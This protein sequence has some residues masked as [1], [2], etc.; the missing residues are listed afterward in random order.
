[1][2]DLPRDLYPP[3]PTEA[4]LPE[5]DGKPVDN[6]L[7]LLAAFILRSIL[8]QIW[9][10][11]MDWFMGVNLGLYDQPGAPAIGPDAFLAI[12]A[13]R[14]R[15]NQKLRLSYVVWE[16]KIMPQ[17]VLEIVSQTPGQEYGDKM[18]KYAAMGI[19]YYTIYN[20]SHYRR[21]QHAP[22]EVY[23]LEHGVYV[24]QPGHPVWM[25]ELGLGIGHEISMQ[26]GIS[27][28][29]LF[30][31]D[32]AGNRYPAPNDAI[33]QERLLRKREAL[34]R[35]ELQEQ[36]EV[37]ARSRIAAEQLLEQVSEQQMMRQRSLITRQ[38][39]QMVGTLSGEL[40]ERINL[41]SLEQLESLAID[42]LSFTTIADLQT[43]L[44]ANLS[45]NIESQNIESQDI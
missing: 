42:L 37:E 24:K 41:L 28:D 31:Y 20:P 36:L 3:L 5:T 16:E 25:S 40:L 32:E 6:E 23:R 8:M 11:R 4:D 14:I 21:D 45:Q 19:L 12:G 2:L 43:W 33:E 15:Q 26:D 38:M 10:D 27:R 39:T 29:W 22:F 30:W 7:Q 1:M 18:Q 13:Q 35:L 44:A 9:G 34:V 17:W